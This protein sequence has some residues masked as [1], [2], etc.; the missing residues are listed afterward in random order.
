[1]NIGKFHD[2]YHLS[3]S[4]H[5]LTPPHRFFEYSGRSPMDL[6]NFELKDTELDEVTRLSRDRSAVSLAAFYHLLLF[7][8][9]QQSMAVDQHQV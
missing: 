5:I 6:S 7:Q 4:I 9:R 2:L 1:M 3:S 8:V